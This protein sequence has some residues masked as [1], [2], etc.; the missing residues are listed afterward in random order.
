MNV[1]LPHHEGTLVDK[2]QHAISAATPS[3][4]KLELGGDQK[5]CA[6]VQDPQC[7][8][9][10]ESLFQWPIWREKFTQE[11]YYDLVVSQHGYVSL[12]F[13]FSML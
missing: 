6:I 7:H 8:R 12:Q 2:L 10:L 9:F 1:T 13:S 4:V 11:F 5:G 3:Q